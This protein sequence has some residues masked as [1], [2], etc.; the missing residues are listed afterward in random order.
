MNNHCFKLYNLTG[1]QM[2]RTKNSLGYLTR[3]GV[4]VTFLKKVIYIH[5]DDSQTYS[6]IFN[7]F[8]YFMAIGKFQCNERNLKWLQRYIYIHNK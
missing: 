8:A 5:L 2:R 6:A 4:K 7:M 3:H 1:S